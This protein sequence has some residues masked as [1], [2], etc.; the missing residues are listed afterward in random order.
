MDYLRYYLPVLVQLA[1]YGGFAL[2]GEAVWI[3]IASLPALGLIDS[4]LPNDMVP[5]RMRD[6]LLADLPVWTSTLLAVG[7]YAMAAA[8]VARTPHINPSQYARAILSLAWLSV[9][10]LVP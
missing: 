1:A 7:L 4:L 2:G 3:G 10:P 8:W 6:G 5:R 9:V